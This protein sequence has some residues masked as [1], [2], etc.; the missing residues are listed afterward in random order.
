M[1][2][3]HETPAPAPAPLRWSYD[4]FRLDAEVVLRGQVALLW[5]WSPAVGYKGLGDWQPHAQCLGRCQL[6]EL[7]DAAWRVVVIDGQGVRQVV[8]QGQ[9]QTGAAAL[10]IERS[11]SG[12]TVITLAGQ[13]L[14]QGELPAGGGA[15]GLLAGVWSHVAV[16]RLAVS[17]K[18]R[19]ATAWYVA[20]DAFSGAGGNPNEWQITPHA[21]FR[22]GKALVHRGDGGRA[23]WSVRAS[24]LNLWAPRGPDG[25]AYTV[26][27]DGRKVAMVECRAAQ[28]AASAPVWQSGPLPYGAHTVVLRSARG[29]LVVDALEAVVR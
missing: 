27:L 25:V 15:P 22:F 24:A 9:R 8:A 14:W 4:A 7:D 23:K 5:A 3:G 28:A 10:T 21:A 29:P 12:S 26:E 18:R 11:I 19:P 16:G 17:G 2:S 13:R 20:E 1:L 6:L